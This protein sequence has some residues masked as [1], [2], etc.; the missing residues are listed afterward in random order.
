MKKIIFRLIILII[1]ITLVFFIYISTVGIKTNKLNN[2]ISNQ[3]KAVN[4][5]FE[6]ELKDIVIVLDPIKFKLNLKTLGTNL[7]YKDKIIQFERIKS[8]VSVKSLINNQFS[9]KELNISTKSI[10]IKNMISFIRAIENDPKL[11]IAEKFIKKGFLIADVDLEFDQNGNIKN[12]Y[13]ISGY[14]KQGKIDFFEKY[15]LSK[16]NFIFNLKKDELNLDDFTLS[17]NNKDLEISNLKAKKERKIF[18][19]SGKL[20][21][22]QDILNE[23]EINQILSDNYLKLPINKIIF[24]S[25]NQFF[26]EVNNRFKFKNLKLDSKIGIKELILKNELDINK[27]FPKLEKEIIFTNHKIDF[28]YHKE[29]WKIKGLGEFLL[30]KQDKIEYNIKKKGNNISFETLFKIN[31]SPFKVDLL[32]YQKKEKSNL[33]IIINGRKDLKNNLYFEKIALLE[34]DNKIKIQNLLISKD[35]EIQ[36]L[37]K[38]N[39]NYEDQNELRNKISIIKKKKNY[40]LSGDSFNANKLIESLLES[41]NDNINIFKGDTKFDIEIN[42]T[43]LDKDTV[44]NGLKGFLIFRD[45]NLLEADLRSKFSNNKD[46]KFTVKTNASEKITT[47]FSG[48][49]KPLVNRYKFIKGFE[50]GSLDFYSIKKDNKTKSTLKIYDFKL[51]ELPVLTK[52]LTLASLQGIADLLSGEGIRFNEFEMNFSNKDQLMTIGEIYAIGPAIS[53]LMSGYL[54]SDKL[55]SLRGTLVPATTLNKTIGS[56]PILGN[57]LVGKKTGEGVFGVSFKIKGPP[58]KLETS[59]NPI[60]TLT[61]RFITRTLEKIKKSN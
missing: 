19:I 45:N 30:N 57:I 53:I 28:N 16:I 36:K 42:K 46:I 15:N 26:F 23:K 13:K 9:L 47:L 31:E 7:I 38:I 60:K 44:I 6:I 18:Q 40:L 32:N 8:S 1:S 24:S 27:I 2:Q 3:V 14:I 37:K 50:E 51:K 22:K 35:Y 49:A 21:N 11:Y 59:V 29:I 54:E 41:N 56:I 5:N 58:K 33:E 34:N 17:L 39:F 48:E 4:E 20:S 10:E 55:V 43:Y 25:E 12:N 52:I 61:P